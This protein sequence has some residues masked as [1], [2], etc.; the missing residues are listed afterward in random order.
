MAGSPALTCRF[1][2]SD[3]ALDTDQ[4]QIG[5]SHGDHTFGWSVSVAFDEVAD[6]VRAGVS[7]A[8]AVAAHVDLGEFDR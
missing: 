8:G 3:Q 4:C 2:S 6:D 7:V 5:P 1:D